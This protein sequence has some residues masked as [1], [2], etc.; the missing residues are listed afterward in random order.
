MSKIKGFPL[1]ETRQIAYTIIFYIWIRKNVHQYRLILALSLCK[2]F[3]DTVSLRKSMTKVANLLKAL[4]SLVF[5]SNHAAM[6]NC[7]APYVITNCGS[8]IFQWIITSKTSYNQRGHATLAIYGHERCV[9]SLG[10]PNSREDSPSVADDT[11]SNRG[12]CKSIHHSSNGHIYFSAWQ[13][14]VANEFTV[15]LSANSIF[16]FAIGDFIFTFICW[17]NPSSFLSLK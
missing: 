17:P 13:S 6:G 8:L 15:C 10:T 16:E 7:D 11:P 5:I 4:S 12:N 1:N 3:I 9:S 2:P 14:I